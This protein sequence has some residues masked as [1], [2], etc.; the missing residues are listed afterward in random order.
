MEHLLVV[1]PDGTVEFI[2]DDR[3]APVLEAGD[4]NVR[5]ASHVE[6][7]PD[8]RWQADLAPVGGPQLPATATRHAAL[9]QENR[10]LEV[11]LLLHA[12]PFPAH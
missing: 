4:F 1:R 9:A 7:T 11:H 2:Y 3:L 10:W 6:P 8:G 5:R 12:Q